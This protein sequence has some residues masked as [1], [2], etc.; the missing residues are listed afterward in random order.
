MV[1][2]ITI[3][4]LKI[5]QMENINLKSILD[6]EKHQ[7]DTLIDVI[8]N[9][10]EGY[11]LEAYITTKKLEYVVKS[12]IEILQPMAITEA[13]KQKGNTLYGAEVNVK[14]T[15]VRY[16]FLECGYLPY[17]NLISDKK[18]IETDLK[19]METLLKSINKK[20]TIV[21][22]VSGEILEVKPPIRTSGT[23]IVLTIK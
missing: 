6:S 7:L 12:L 3:K 20:T 5:K 19:G 23:S 2:N 22:E 18:Q 21:D 1:N 8:V 13:E 11:E 14:D 16:N 15:G 4:L 10:A 17:N 9:E